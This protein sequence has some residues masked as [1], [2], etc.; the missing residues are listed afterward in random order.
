MV[1]IN[2]KGCSLN[3]GALSLFHDCKIRN[4]TSDPGSKFQSTKHKHK[5]R[6]GWFLAE[7]EGVT[8]C[9]VCGLRCDRIG[10]RRIGR[11]TEKE[12]KKGRGDNNQ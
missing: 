6:N 2:R 4:S 12:G 7:C 9:G 1:E 11:Y 10:D 5:I 3:D 8:V